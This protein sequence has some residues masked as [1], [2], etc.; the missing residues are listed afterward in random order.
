[1]Y[2]HVHVV[3]KVTICFP[4]RTDLRY[5][6][7]N[8]VVGPTDEIT[9]GPIYSTL[10]RQ[11]IYSPT[12]QPPIDESPDHLPLQQTGSLSKERLLRHS[13]GDH[14]S[15][16]GDIHFIQTAIDAPDAREGQRFPYDSRPSTGS[17]G[18]VVSPP[19]RGP[20]RNV[21][22]AT[23]PIPDYEP[24]DENY[25]GSPTNPHFPSSRKASSSD[26]T[27]DRKFSLASSVTTSTGTGSFPPSSASRDD[28]FSNR[29]ASQSGAMVSQQV[30]VST[31]YLRNINSRSSID[32]HSASPVLPLRPSEIVDEEERRNSNCS[33]EPP[34]YTSRPP[35]LG[36]APSNSMLDN[37][38]YGRV[39]PP[40]PTAI[41]SEGD[42]HWYIQSS[43]ISLN[44][45]T[46]GTRNLNGRSSE[47]VP[48][49]SIH[50]SAI[51]YEPHT[52]RKNEHK[53]SVSTSSPRFRVSTDDKRHH[54]PQP[55]TE[56]TNSQPDRITP[57]PYSEA[58][59]DGMTPQPYSEAM[60]TE[61]NIGSLASHSSF[62]ASRDMPKF[63][64][65]TVTV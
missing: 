61:S 7:N 16:D 47:I 6:I 46:P 27:R 41:D 35:S 20:S 38:A 28:I 33:E 19:Q 31:A 1:M 15:L 12:S 62:G 65:I 26:S 29:S 50:N 45:N 54:T 58:V 53:N 13:S 14:E 2:I 22:S 36:I 10:N 59:R 37:S 39:D 24:L 56:A 52:V 8:H 55:Y 17:S 30:P 60:P 5:G 11:N 21:V 44:S 48:Y 25:R 4:Y 63:G 9:E 43:D 18:R 57:Q 3:I 51:P 34:P 49:A 42:Q 23:N 32:H 40:A 64:R